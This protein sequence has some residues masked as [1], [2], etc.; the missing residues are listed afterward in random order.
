MTRRSRTPDPSHRVT[1]MAASYDVT[2]AVIGDSRTAKSEL[3]PTDKHYKQPYVKR[4]KATVQ[5][6]E[7]E[8]FVDVLERA[9]GAM[10]L[11]GLGASVAFFRPEDEERVAGGRVSAA[12]P[13]VDERGRVTFGHYFHEVRFGDLIRSGEAGA[14][15][16]DPFRPYIVL[17]PGV[18]NG[19]LP[20]WETIKAVWDAM[21]YVLA[22]IANAGGAAAAAYA[23]KK[24]I[25]DRLRKKTQA[26]SKVID[27]RSGDWASRNGQPYD[28]QEWL[29]DRPWLPADLVPLLD[30]SESEAEAVLWA[31][32]FA[33]AS[34]GLWRRDADQEARLLGET[35]NV[36]I[37]GYVHEA[38]DE[39][40]QHLLRE[41]VDHFLETGNARRVDW[42]RF[43][44]RGAPGLVRRRLM[45]VFSWL[46]RARAWLRSR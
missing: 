25:I 26:V 16:G 14:L 18:G 11:D 23:V 31:F 46:Y 30:C 3:G 41:E 37:R 20:D 5:A 34:L 29:D 42:H 13:L 44:W 40:V 8:P 38:S 10:G 24:G 45:R 4:L 19:V 1:H 17:R 35:M 2:V 39:Q 9:A 36:A 12:V 15:S 7:A 22:R 32:G 43:E 27:A 28:V 33:P 21:D 6:S